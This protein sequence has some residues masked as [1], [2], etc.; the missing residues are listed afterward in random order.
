MGTMHAEFRCPCGA[1]H[2]NMTDHPA[3]PTEKL[4]PAHV[5]GSGY[6]GIVKADGTTEGAPP[7]EYAKGHEAPELYR[8]FVSQ[9]A[10]KAAATPALGDNGNTP[11]AEDTAA[12]EAA[13]EAVTEES[14]VDPDRVHVS[15]KRGSDQPPKKK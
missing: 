9:E 11:A 7:P 14:G 12:E 3:G 15:R 2:G 1:E 5:G 4:C 6:R 8:D 10:A 13:S